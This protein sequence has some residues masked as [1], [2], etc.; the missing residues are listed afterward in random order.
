MRNGIKNAG[1]RVPGH[2]WCSAFCRELCLR[3]QMCF[4]AYRLNDPAVA[5]ASRKRFCHNG[6]NCLN[7][8]VAVMEKMES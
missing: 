6:P 3:L 4:L 2:L 7:A 8:P 1:A 5:A